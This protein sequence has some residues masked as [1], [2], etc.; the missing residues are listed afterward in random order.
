MAAEM[1][2]LG[3]DHRASNGKAKL[4]GS[5]PTVPAHTPAPDDVARLERELQKAEAVS[6]KWSE[7]RAALP[8]GSS[9][10]RISQR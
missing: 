3:P 4:Q 1:Q 6:E 2:K 5:R 9:R 10:A 8:F 7:R